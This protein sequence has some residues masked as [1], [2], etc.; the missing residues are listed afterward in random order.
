MRPAAGALCAF[1]A[2]GQ[3]ND[4]QMAVVEAPEGPLLVIAG[5][6]SG[7]TRTLTWRVARLIHDG[8]DPE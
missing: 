5:A 1:D 4:E 2:G 6:G 8:L 3:L 7:K